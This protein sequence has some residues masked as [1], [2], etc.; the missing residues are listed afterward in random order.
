M[1]FD[2]ATKLKIV[3]ALLQFNTRLEIFESDSKAI[4]EL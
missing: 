1:Q 2:P 3:K 4:T